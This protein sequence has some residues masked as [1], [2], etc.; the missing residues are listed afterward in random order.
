M[1]GRRLADLFAVASTTKNIIKRHVD[2]QLHNA[3]RIAAT[4]SVTKAIKRNFRGSPIVTSSSRPL[5][6]SSVPAK[7]IDEDP[8]I[9]GKN[10][11]VFYERS[12]SHSTTQPSRPEGMNPKSSRS[13]R[14]QTLKAA[15]PSTKSKPMNPIQDQHVRK[16]STERTTPIPSETA[17]DTTES[18]DLRKNLD[19][20]VYY[21]TQA[22]TSP[23]TN[24]PDHIP[25][26]A[27]Q[28]NTSH[29]KLSEG[30][31]SEIQYARDTTQ[32]P[33]EPQSKSVNPEGTPSDS[34]GIK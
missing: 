16:M 4:S 3:A 21:E 33:T 1:S 2:I 26:E 27:A 9:K 20:E 13:K 25:Q 31:D 15:S 22:T 12:D 14:E 18:S 19:E 28:P 8:L 5:K 24:G 10:Q 29:D 30:I 6:P 7:K 11:E 17:G 32:W 34:S 23:N